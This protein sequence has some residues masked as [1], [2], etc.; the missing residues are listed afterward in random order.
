MVACIPPEPTNGNT[1][2]NEEGVDDCP[3]VRRCIVWSNHLDHALLM[4]SERAR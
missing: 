4:L 1:G 3:R 2:T